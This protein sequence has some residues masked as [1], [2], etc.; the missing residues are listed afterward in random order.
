MEGHKGPIIEII[1]IQP[2][3]LNVIGAN[4]A[5]ESKEFEQENEKPK[6]LTC[7]LDNTIRFWE[8]KDMSTL[9]VMENDPKSELSCMAYLMNCGLVATGHE[10]GQIRLWNLEI[11]T[12]VVLSCEPA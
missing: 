7:S 8:S 3:D 2:E 11:G 12:H 5:E 1:V 9:S 10:D 6:I 4:D